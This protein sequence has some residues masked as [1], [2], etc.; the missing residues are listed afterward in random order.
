MSLVY[1]VT[2]NIKKRLV[3][4]IQDG[5]YL[6]KIKWFLVRTGIRALTSSPPVMSIFLEI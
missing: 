3:M 6:G 1:P 2:K 5:A 4:M